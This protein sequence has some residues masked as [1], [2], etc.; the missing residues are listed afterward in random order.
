VEDGQSRI[1]ITKKI[2]GLSDIR[3]VSKQP[4]DIPTVITVARCEIS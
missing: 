1:D 4:P 3:G 2:R